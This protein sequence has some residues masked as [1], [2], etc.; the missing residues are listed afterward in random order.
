MDFAMSRLSSAWNDQWAGGELHQA[1][2]RFHLV[3][4][5][6]VAALAGVVLGSVIAMLVRAARP[7][8]DAQVSG[9]KGAIL[10]GGLASVLALAAGLAAIELFGRHAR[11]I[12]P[13][14]RA[15]AAY[16]T[17]CLVAAGVNLIAGI[18]TIAL[19]A[20]NGVG[21][22]LWLP[23]LLLVVLNALGMLLA[24]PRVAHLRTFKNVPLLP[25]LHV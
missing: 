20:A 9:G 13:L 3:A 18:V 15:T 25:Y 8:A 21:N 22:M 5:G 24:I 12:G 14:I 10:W 23:E 11:R 2:R 16:V 4:G 7:I 17:G 1:V 19:I 6:I